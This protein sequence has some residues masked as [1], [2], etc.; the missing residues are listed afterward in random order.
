MIEKAIE[1][2]N[3]NKLEKSTKPA[4]GLYPHQWFWDSCFIS[5]GLSWVDID[6]AKQEILSLLS[7]QWE[8]GM[9]PHI[10]FSGETS[11]H[12]GPGYWKSS[13]HGG[14]RLVETT[15]ITQPPMLAEA[16]NKVAA[17]L[18]QKQK[19]QWY[20][21]TLP[22]LIKCHTWVY[23]NRRYGNSPFISL[24]HP[25]ECGMDNTPYWLKEVRSAVPLKIR[26]LRALGQ[27]KLLNKLR[28]D[29]STV[30]ASQRPNSAD[31]YSFYSFVKQ[32]SRQSYNLDKIIE[33]TRIPVIEDLLYNSVL[34]R[35]NTLL[36]QMSAEAEIPLK[37]ELIDAIGNT[38]NEIKQLYNNGSFWSRDRRTKNLIQ[39][40][41]VAEFIL[42][43][44]GALTKE[45]ALGV[46]NKIKEGETWWPKDGIATV[47]INS[48]WFLE[49]NYWRGPVW[50]N[51]NWL[52]I[53]GL[54]RYNFLDLA[55]KL[56]QQT[57]SLIEEG[58]DFSEYYSAL[59][60]SSAGSKDFSWTAALYID[61]INQK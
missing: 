1:V 28:K 52:I 61:L 60:G 41:T 16:I 5:I 33:N 15:C 48:D 46:M 55:N 7:G 51:I 57:I 50:V 9:I 32:A 30:P 26:T 31:L 54:K 39:I 24:I 6:R 18:D 17:R 35:A 47:P 44:S 49:K 22:G 43:Y 8:N 59:D 21:Q 42:L 53:E 36:L 20:K 19:Q 37:P 29:T 13:R 45:Q 2:L 12:F 58:S 56:K 14:P 38:K 10:I 23:E 25:W 34:I 40:E 4:L 11:Y 27:E 3:K